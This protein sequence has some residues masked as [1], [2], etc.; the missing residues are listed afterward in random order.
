M[1]IHYKFVYNRLDQLLLFLKNEVDSEERISLVWNGPQLQDFHCVKQKTE[2]TDV[3]NV[4]T[5]ND[6]FSGDVKVTTN[7]RNF[8]KKCNENGTNTVRTENWTPS[9][10]L[11]KTKWLS[12][13]EISRNSTPCG[14]LV[15]T[16]GSNIEEAVENSL[17]KKH[18]SSMKNCWQFLITMRLRSTL[19]LL[20]TS[21]NRKV[22]F[23]S[24][25]L[26]KIFKQQVFQICTTWVTSTALNVSSTC[27]DWHK[28]VLETS[29]W[30]FHFNKR[31]KEPAGGGQG[32]V[33]I[34]VVLDGC[35]NKM[36][37]DWPM[38]HIVT[39]FPGI[40][41]CIS[42]MKVNTAL[43]GLIR[44]A[45]CIFKLQMINVMNY[46][47]MHTCNRSVEKCCCKCLQTQE[48]FPQNVI[49]IKQT[50]SL[51]A[52]WHIALTS[53]SLWHIQWVFQK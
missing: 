51:C 47:I 1:L 5:A 25:C 37:L 39:L 22:C 3:Q 26:L 15:G 46:G 42:V 49:S 19:D 50:F 23:L 35:D 38:E 36:R 2:L 53:K 18:L 24:Q 17:R 6:I 11:R 32:G 7:S 48:Q 34:D 28:K 30:V 21:E 29:T 40:D 41:N 52:T 4:L 33:V 20:L 14:C 12:F 10:G 44:H 16:A 13:W 43:A 27:G 45:Q 31:E 9:T 8:C